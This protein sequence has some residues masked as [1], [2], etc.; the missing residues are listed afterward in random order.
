[1]TIY[2]AEL[3]QHVSTLQQALAEQRRVSDEVQASARVAQ[4]Q[5]QQLKQQLEQ[6][7]SAFEAKDTEVSSIKVIWHSS[8]LYSTKYIAVQ[9]LSSLL[10]LLLSDLQSAVGW[11][12]FGRS[13]AKNRLYNI[14]VYKTCQYQFRKAS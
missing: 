9:C 4:Q 6:M 10:S 5:G 13:Q 1:M 7:R 11:K 12:S 3:D 8:Y 14:L 2:A